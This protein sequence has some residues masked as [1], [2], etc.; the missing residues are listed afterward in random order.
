MIQKKADEKIKADN[1]MHL[2]IIP[3]ENKDLLDRTYS[4][5]KMNMEDTWHKCIVNHD[6]YKIITSKELLKNVSGSK[7]KELKEYLSQRYWNEK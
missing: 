2:H 5:S 4:C 6:K 7:Y 3:N 1:Y